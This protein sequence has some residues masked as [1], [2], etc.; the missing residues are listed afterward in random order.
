MTTAEGASPR[1]LF[2]VNPMPFESPRGYLCRVAAD[3]GYDSPA[4]LTT[5]AGF[6]GSEAALDRED[7]VHRLAHLLRL[8]PEE[9]VAMCYR[10]VNSGGHRRRIFCGKPVSTNE[11]NIGKPRVC[12]ACLQEHSIWWAVWDL[13]LVAACPLHR[14]ILLDHCPGCKK[15]LA[16]QRPSVH[17]CRC[18]FDLRT[19]LPETADTDLVAI[20]AVIYRATGFSIG[21]A[22]E[23]EIK[24]YDFPPEIAGLTLGPLLV[25]LGCAGSFGHAVIPRRKRQHITP[26]DL[27]VAIQVGRT[28]ASLLRNWPHRL[29]G[30][31]KDMVPKDFEDAAALRFRE[32]FGT[33]YFRLFR[34]LPRKEFGFFHDV[35]EE[36]V[37][38]DWRGLIRGQHRFFSVAIREKSPWIPI[39][40]AAREARVAYDRMQSLVRQGQIEGERFKFRRGRI[41]CWIKRASL[42]QWMIT[43]DAEFGQYIALREVVHILG[44]RDVHVKHLAQAGLIRTAQGSACGLPRGRQFSFSR[45]DVMKIK[46]AFEKGAVPEQG[47][48]M[49]TEFIALRDA[50]RKYLGRSGLAAAI[51]AVVDGTL[52]P[53]AYTP[54]FPGITGYLF[55][56]AHLRSYRPVLADIEVPLGGFLN[57]SEAA[58]RLDSQIPEIHTLVELGILAGPTGFQLGRSKLVAA[59]DVQRFSTQYVRIHV[60][61]RQLRV[62]ERWL[63]Y[64]LKKSGAPML[65]VAVGPSQKVYFLEKEAAAKLQIPPPG[66]SPV[67]VR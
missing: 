4:W 27:K 58:S 66:K 37:S 61:A 67:S 9:W 18:S 23:G 24:R 12:P 65:T 16:W 10:H 49:S 33:F 43:R 50:I 64:Y 36:F 62:V 25:L 40:Q 55:P 26:T 53:V 3:H 28:A 63:R 41:Q 34:G 51:C 22:A 44:L 30:A 15:L 8:E 20:N 60:L 11:L 52:V 14:C 7:R 29:R 2:R 45:E 54:R 59:A 13:C 47:N 42:S 46:Q 48:S 32:I 17:E 35:F 57:Y 21:G 39:N 6:S 56:S 38:A 1:L 31:L 5:L 19:V